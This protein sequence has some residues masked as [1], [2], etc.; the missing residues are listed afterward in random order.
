MAIFMVLYE[1]PI[2]NTEEQ[3]KCRFVTWQ[4]NFNKLLALWF[5]AQEKDM[6]CIPKS[7][8]LLKDLEW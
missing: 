1:M 2:L 6:D 7:W 4:E 3:W 5:I 8:D